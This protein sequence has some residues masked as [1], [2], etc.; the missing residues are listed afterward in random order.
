MSIAFLH[1][2][3][4][5]FHLFGFVLVFETGDLGQEIQNTRRMFDVS[6]GVWTVDMIF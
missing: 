2:F 3:I 4:P 6:F 5:F 1:I